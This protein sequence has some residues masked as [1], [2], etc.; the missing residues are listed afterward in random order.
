MV[1]M[2]VALLTLFRGD[3]MSRGILRLAAGMAAAASLSLTPLPLYAGGGCGCEAP[4]STVYH[5]HSR[6]HHGHCRSYPPMGMVV[7][8]APVMAAPMM[9]APALMAPQQAMMVAPMQSLTVAQPSTVLN[10]TAP[11]QN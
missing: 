11:A 5:V 10:V 8:S 1:W 9:M 7:Q 2:C 3:D 6:C 4:S